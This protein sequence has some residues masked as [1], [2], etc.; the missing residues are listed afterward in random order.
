[1]AAREHECVDCKALPEFGPA[2][3][4]GPFRPPSPRPA[5]HGG[6]RSRRCTTHHRA[7]RKGQSARRADARVVRVYGLAPGEYEQLLAFQGGT[8]AIPSCR[9]SG[10]RKRLA[11]DHDHVTGEPRGLLCGPHNYELLGKYAGDLQAGLDYLASPPAARMRAA[12]LRRTG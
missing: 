12:R 6:P 9:A 3:G 2:A 4:A 8:C 7:H 5:P 10:K 11:V 1:M